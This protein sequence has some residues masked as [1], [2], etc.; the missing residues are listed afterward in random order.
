M[1]C[2]IYAWECDVFDVI[3][4]IIYLL[5]L[6]KTP[7]VFDHYRN[8]IVGYCQNFFQ[9]TSKLLRRSVIHFFFFV[10]FR[11]ITFEEIRS[12]VSRNEAKV[13]SYSERQYRETIK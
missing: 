2:E 8:G 6:F 10:E 1:L 12:P 9:F 11:F 13:C 3:I 7:L 4:L 5:V